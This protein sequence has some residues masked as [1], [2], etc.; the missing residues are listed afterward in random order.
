MD[1]FTA[2]NEKYLTFI[3]VFSKY[4]QAYLLKDGT[5]VSIL[6]G[7]LQFATHHGLPYTI[8]TDDVAEFTNQ[9][10]AEFI[11]THNINHHKTL[12]H[13]PN[14]NGNI[15]RFHSTLLEHLRIKLRHKDEPIVNLMP[16]A[17]IG[18]N[19]SIH[20]FNKCKPFDLITEPF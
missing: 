7:L 18:Y 19:S 15:E 17:I 14:D 2:H 5:A 4:G 1:L 16:Y 8:V 3:D 12:A 13:A 10:F 20:I 6:Q 9:L 11:R